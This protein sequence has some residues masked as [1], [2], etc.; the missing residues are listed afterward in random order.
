MKAVFILFDSLKRHL[1]A[2]YGGKRVPTPN[3]A[4]LAE[5]AATFE[6]HYVG[7]LPCMPARR[8]LQAG[9]LSFLHRNWGPNRARC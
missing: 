8:D 4:C 6:R 7:S 1:L 9:R 5:R 3:L 2:P